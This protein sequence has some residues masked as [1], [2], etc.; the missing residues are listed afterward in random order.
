MARTAEDT[1]TKLKVFAGGQVAWMSRKI[2]AMG[3][4]F[5]DVKLEMKKVTWPTR[6]DVYAQTVIVL[7]VVFFF[8]YF[9]WGTNLALSYLVNKLIEYISK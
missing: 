2:Q 5:R 4:F 8:A 1:E 6:G 3:Q 9:L 7:I